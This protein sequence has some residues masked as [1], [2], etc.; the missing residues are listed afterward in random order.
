MLLISSIMGLSMVAG[1]PLVTKLAA[2]RGLVHCAAGAR[3]EAG[4]GPK[5]GRSMG[6]WR[7]A[8]YSASKGW[9]SADQLEPNG[10]HDHSCGRFRGAPLGLSLTGGA[11]ARRGA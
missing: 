11:A 6:K 4:A 2:F 1:A 3:A 8:A 10:C 5:P 7:V 9:C